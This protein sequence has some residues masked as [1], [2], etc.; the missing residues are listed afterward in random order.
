MHSRKRQSKLSEES[1]ELKIPTIIFRKFSLSL[2]FYI[3]S[4][5]IQMSWREFA[6]VGRSVEG[7][8][9]R[10]P[11]WIASSGMDASIR[12]IAIFV[13][14]FGPNRMGFA[15]ITKVSRSR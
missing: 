8:I 10:A 2:A 15:T 11:R 4:T 1:F 14:K 9:L 12:K 3:N 5:I 13:Q 7:R 6:K